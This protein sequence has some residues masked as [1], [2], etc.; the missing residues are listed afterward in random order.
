MVGPDSPSAGGHMAGRKKRRRNKNE[1]KKKCE[2]E[3]GTCRK[4]SKTLTWKQ[5]AQINNISSGWGY[6]LKH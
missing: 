5:D 6:A 2:K 1:K 3:M 4:G